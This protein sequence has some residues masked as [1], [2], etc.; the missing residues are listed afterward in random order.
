[1]AYY[2]QNEREKAILE[3]QKLLRTLSYSDP[4]IG[5]VRLNGNYDNDT[6][7]AVR[8]FQ[9]KYGLPV[10]GIVDHTTYQVLTAVEKAQQEAS[11]LARAV[12]LLPRGV[13]YEL[14]PGLEDNVVYVIQH[15]LE[16]VSREASELEGVVLNG[17]Y[18]EAT[19]DAVKAF[20]RLNL[21]EMTGVLDAI[22]FNRL[23]DEYE[24][25]NSYNE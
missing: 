20:Q 14:Y 13:E 21:L 3:V 22:T 9:E 17:V 18:D 4:D 7:E 6:R 8:Q 10:T 2:N 19:E 12:Y 15:M 25:I 23:A 1:M 5:R 24:R 11:Q 16:V